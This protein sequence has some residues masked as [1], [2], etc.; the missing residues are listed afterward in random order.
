MTERLAK[1]LSLIFHPLWMPLIIYLLVRW[2]D[3]YYIGQ[4]QA[5]NFVI[6]LLL[7]NIVAPALSMLIMIKYGMLSSIELRDRK[8]RFGPYLLVIFYYILSYT[9]LK[10]QGPILPQEVFSFFVSV[11]LS[12]IV[13]LS[14]N[15]IWKISVHLLAQGGVFGTLL[16]LNSLHKSDINVFLMISALA[17]GLT[18]YSRLKLHAHTHGQ[19]YA[20]FILGVVMNWVII[21]MK[22]SF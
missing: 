9:M 6:L 18:A 8:E 10:W 2:L 20:G 1:V 7:V 13:S 17:A 19:V 15:M 14:I 4:T 5:D 16:A 22:I 3:P 12:L 21:S 11:I